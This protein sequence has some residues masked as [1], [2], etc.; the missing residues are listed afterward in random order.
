MTMA[1]EHNDGR[2]RKLS[3][4]A[5]DTALLLLFGCCAL[6]ISVYLHFGLENVADTDPF[7][8]YSHAHL[9][10]VH[11]PLYG[12]FPWPTISIVS[13]EPGDLWYGFHILL[14][15]MARAESSVP[16]MKC[17]SAVVTA[18]SLV[19][20]SL[21][22]L[23]LRIRFPYY[24]SLLLLAA[25]GD[26]MTRFMMLRPQELSTALVLL[27]VAALLMKRPRVM[28]LAA[29][30]TC[31]IHLTMAGLLAVC[32]AA[33]I[34]LGRL[35]GV[36]TSRGTAALL[37]AAAAAGCLLRPHPWWALHLL[38]V[39]TGELALAKLAGVNLDWGTEL[40]PMKPALFWSM[41]A[42]FVV[43][44][45]AT[46]IAG[47]ASLRRRAL[48]PEQR[49]FLDW[50]FTLSIVFFAM[51][52]LSASRSKDEWAAFS[53][54]FMGGAY[55]WLLAPRVEEWAARRSLPHVRGACAGVLGVAVALLGAQSLSVSRQL[56]DGNFN[57]Y[58][59]REAAGWLREHAQP[60]QIVFTSY[61]MYFPELLFWD[62]D[63]YY[64]GAADPI[65]EYAQSRRKYWEWVSLSYP[66][67][68]DHVTDQPVS[69]PGPPI[70]VHT[71]LVRDFHASYVMAFRQ[72]QPRLLNDLA[73]DRRFKLVYFDGGLAIFRV[74]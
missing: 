27:V 68:W 34:G 24:W 58:R 19:C 41:Y 40:Y 7:Y 44:W 10:A 21:P 70:D 2:A 72:F 51:I 54:A 22:L 74:L 48:S 33:A 55:T 32:A 23:T 53:V 6:L 45:L 47:A 30:L 38:W 15:P 8:H 73:S 36:R 59:F 66:G 16:A 3:P 71:A 52:F 28:A 46:L 69:R 63:N 64:L 29:F 43:L 20:F 65:F 11:G 1:D 60:G 42:P 49:T 4:A 5:V 39:Q 61:W 31:W 12:R 57:P 62:P 9:Y 50:S 17:C 25:S 37:V 13:R 14:A 26:E 56:I 35:H 67:F 18:A